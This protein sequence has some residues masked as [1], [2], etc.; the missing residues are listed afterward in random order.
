MEIA[1]I[2]K[3]T[4]MLSLAQLIYVIL[5]NQVFMILL[6]I[7]FLKYLFFCNFRTGTNLVGSFFTF[8]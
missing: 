7:D 8:F 3:F 5:P 2:Q 4:K 6:S 1:E